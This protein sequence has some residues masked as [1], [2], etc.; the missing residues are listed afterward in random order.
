MFDLTSKLNCRKQALARTTGV[1]F[2]G[3]P[4]YKFKPGGWPYT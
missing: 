1:L 3:V 2:D 4:G